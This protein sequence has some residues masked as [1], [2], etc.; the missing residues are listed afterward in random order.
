[1][2][3]VLAIIFLIPMALISVISFPFDLI[4]NVSKRS[5]FMGILILVALNLILMIFS[6][7]YLNILGIA[8]IYIYCFLLTIKSARY[9]IS[10]NQN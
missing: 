3:R 7:F 4:V 9:L 8:L 10:P 2:N 5:R 1:M 6:R